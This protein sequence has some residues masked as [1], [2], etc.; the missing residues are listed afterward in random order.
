MI[1][2]ELRVRVAHD[3]G[4]CR[5]TFESVDD[6]S[7]SGHRCSFVVLND[8]ARQR[9]LKPQNDYISTTLS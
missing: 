8:C 2:R 3:D 1:E 5:D 4:G 9:R 6:G 7:A